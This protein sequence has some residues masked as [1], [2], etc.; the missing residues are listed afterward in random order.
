MDEKRNNMEPGLDKAYGRWEKD[1]LKRFWLLDLKIR[2][3]DN[4]FGMQTGSLHTFALV[5]YIENNV[6]QRFC[7]RFHQADLS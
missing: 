4:L 7:R 2:E 1:V 3:K 6:R 5:M